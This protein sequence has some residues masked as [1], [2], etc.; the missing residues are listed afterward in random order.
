M[1]QPRSLRL[2][3]PVEP[4]RRN[5]SLFSRLYGKNDVDELVLVINLRLS[6]NFGLEVSV[7]M[8]EVQE[9][10]LSDWN[11]RWI[12]GIFVLQIHDLK[13][14]RIGKPLYGAWKIDY[15]KVVGRFQQ[16][17]DSQACDVRIN[18]DV[19]LGKATC[20]LQ[21]FDALPDLLL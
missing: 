21:G 10:V 16:E 12:V 19:D 17:A 3:R 14:R 9:R 18:T 15:P 20:L 13:Q 5:T 7:L 11:A 8:Q 4:D 1:R 2:A 6:L